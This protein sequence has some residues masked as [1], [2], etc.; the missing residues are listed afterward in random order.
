MRYIRVINIF[1]I[2]II[3]INATF[4]FFVLRYCSLMLMSECPSKMILLLPD[5]GVFSLHNFYYTFRAETHFAVW[6]L[7]GGL[8]QPKFRNT[9]FR[10]VLT[11]CSLIFMP[12]CFS[13]CLCLS[14]DRMQISL[15]LFFV[16]H[17]NI[18]I[19]FSLKEEYWRK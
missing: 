1:S 3:T 5:G 4:C 9:Y 11:V 16:N 7:Q 8:L 6:K 19:C 15:W 17:V 2:V 12:P 13:V 14:Q 18:E 10:S